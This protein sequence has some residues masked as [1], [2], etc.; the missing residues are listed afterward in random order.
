[1]VVYQLKIFQNHQSLSIQLWSK[2]DLFE[3]LQSLYSHDIVGDV[4][5][6]LGLLAAVELVADRPSK[7]PFPA[8]AG[9]AKKMPKMLFDKNIVTLRA[10]DVITICPPLSINKSEIDFI[11]NAIDGALTELEQ[12]LGI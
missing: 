9:L 11:V 12:D 10:A 2:E 6:G 3:Q 7:T 4:R 1:M 8:D 5:G